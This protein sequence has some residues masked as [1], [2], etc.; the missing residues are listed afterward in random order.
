MASRSIPET[1]PVEP[2]PGSGSGPGSESGSD[3]R[4]HRARRIADRLEGLTPAEIASVAGLGLAHRY[5]DGELHLRDVPAQSLLEAYG[6]PLLVIDETRLRDNAKAAISAFEARFAEARVCYA[7]KAGYV[8]PVVRGLLEAGVGL[9]LMS[10]PEL[11]LA[12]AHGATAEALCLNGLGRSK[13]YNARTA[14]LL[15]FLTVVDAESDV[16]ALEAA[17]ARTGQSLPVAVRVTPGSDD[18]DLFD[19]GGSK[20]GADWSGGS[21]DSL[22]R[23]CLAAPHLDVVGI[24]A[25]QLS[26]C[27]DI[28]QFRE[29]VRGLVRVARSSERT[30]GITFRYV[31]I[32]GGLET[33][34]L[35]DRAGVT[36]DDFAEAAAV[37]LA[38][39]GHPVAV[40]VEPGRWLV[41]DA[42]T[43]LTTVVAT[44]R[45]SGRSWLITDVS[46]ALLIPLPEL[47]YHPLPGRLGEAG[48][49][50]DTY[51]VGDQTCDAQ[52][53][54]CP[55]A[56]LPP[57]TVG[58]HM[59]LLNCG[60]YT[61]VFSSAW[62][63]PLPT[64]LLLDTAG[65]VTQV[66]GPA[67]Q[68]DLWRTL[69]GVD[70]SIG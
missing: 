57:T 70:I 4:S 29:A 7:L 31:D 8:A 16:A 58:D 15:P 43:V 37:E 30:H 66:F 32:G 20:L 22:L 49:H 46:A 36:V 69:H 26:H 45:N 68:R 64:T 33:R 54:L 11:Q 39:L 3:A 17:M 60:A 56:R 40:V 50:W 10:D 9:E 18:P 19:V 48:E 47:V 34:F 62:A 21:F 12:L 42:A 6:S 28:Q 35:A 24:H 13:A 38:A 2:E 23:A 63:H 14:D 5:V 59:A 27:A 67:Q 51:A 65:Q 25:H 52:N 55:S 61:T 41:A 1:A 44:K 53:I